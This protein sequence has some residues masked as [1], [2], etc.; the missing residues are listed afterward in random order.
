MAYAVLRHAGIK[1]GKPDY[2]GQ[3]ALI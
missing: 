3:L 2:L 1:L